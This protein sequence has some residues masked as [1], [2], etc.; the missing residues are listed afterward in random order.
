MLPVNH[1][2][3]LK[4]RRLPFQLILSI[5]FNGYIIQHYLLINKISG[6][7][8]EKVILVQIVISDKSRIIDFKGSR[9]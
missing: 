5:F 8:N 2:N 1:K 4:L 7:L 3:P 6:F 9:I